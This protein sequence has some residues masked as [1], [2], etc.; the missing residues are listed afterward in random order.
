MIG[1]LTPSQV[2]APIGKTRRWR[3]SSKA[4]TQGCRKIDRE[5]LLWL[6]FRLCQLPLL[7]SRALTAAAWR[8]RTS[9][10]CV[11]SFDC[12]S[13]VIAGF[14]GGRSSTGKYSFAEVGASARASINDELELAQPPSSE[15]LSNNTAPAARDVICLLEFGASMYARSTSVCG[16]IMAIKSPIDGVC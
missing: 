9:I 12:S 7:L 10:S 3:E 13:I 4:G 11:L 5:C 14:F 8:S 15:R 2:V 6:A 1:H 16:P